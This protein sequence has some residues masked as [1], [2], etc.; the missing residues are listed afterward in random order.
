MGNLKI[1]KTS[2][3]DIEIY[4]NNRFFLEKNKIIIPFGN[5]QYEFK[6]KERLGVNN[7]LPLFESVREPKL[8]KILLNDN[9]CLE[10]LIYLEKPATQTEITQVINSVIAEKEDYTNEDI[11]FAIDK[12]FGIKEMIDLSSIEEFYY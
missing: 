2:G 11:Y 6:I 12:A 7:M 8:N 9:S 5:K 4:Y 3:K 1:I 10:D